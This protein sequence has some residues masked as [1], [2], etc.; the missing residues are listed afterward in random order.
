MKIF[1]SIIRRPKSAKEPT[2]LHPSN[3]MKSE[4]VRSSAPSQETKTT[5]PEKESLKVTDTA[6]LEKC[7]QL[8]NAPQYAEM[9]FYCPIRNAKI[10]CHSIIIDKLGDLTKFIIASLYKGHSIAEIGD[11]TQMGSTTV[12]EELDYLIRGGLIESDEATLTELGKQYGKLLEMFDELSDGI[13]VAFNVFSDEFEKD[14][15]EKYTNEADS[16]YILKGHF[17]PA[18]ARNDNYANSKTIARHMIISDIPFCSEIKDSLYATVRIE[19]KETRYK[20]VRIRNFD[21]GSSLESEH[22]VKVAI[23]FDRITYKPRYSWIDQY[24]DVI[25]QV[26][27][28]CEKNEELLSDK[29]MRLVSAAQEENE[30]LEITKEINTISGTFKRFKNNLTELA[31]EKSLYVM[32]RQPVQLVLADESCTGIYLEEVYREQL[33]HVCYYPFRQM[34]V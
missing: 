26:N 24:R 4:T 1:G 19:K 34:E 28:I 16:K 21:N 9:V 29:A 2:V 20:V 17:I 22:C 7:L 30:A 33:Y 14:E 8:E 25:P 10:F 13:D 32:D 5:K 18:L 12:K 27:T 6:A 11:L 31:G 15:E 3:S 23:P